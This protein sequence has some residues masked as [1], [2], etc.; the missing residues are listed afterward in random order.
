MVYGNK[1]TDTSD[2]CIIQETNFFE[3][4]KDIVEKIKQGLKKI[5]EL[6]Q[7]YIFNKKDEDDLG[8]GYRK[9]SQEEFHQ[10]YKSKFGDD[11]GYSDN[12]NNSKEDDGTV[13]VSFINPYYESDIDKILNESD[14]ICQFM[15]NNG[16]KDNNSG[17]HA[18]KVAEDL[19]NTISKN[20]DLSKENSST[21]RKEKIDSFDKYQ[22]LIKDTEKLKEIKSKIKKKIT[23]FHPDIYKSKLDKMVKDANE[24]NTENLKSEAENYQKDYKRITQYSQSL[25]RVFNSID[26][27]IKSNESVI[28]RMR[29][30][31]ENINKE[32]N[33]DQF[34]NT[35][36][37]TSEMN[38][39]SNMIKDIFDF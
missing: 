34:N 28:N 35:E 19:S 12:Y 13:K 9:M 24:G 31:F 30:E 29:S 15:N 33:N 20:L 36:K 26:K 17:D 32:T 38:E 16:K 6:I 22:K 4:I 14:N 21:V 3:F 5:W 2:I 39:T 8:N 25:I 1:Y 11:D 18:S 27:G 7:K 37:E 10:W 23:K